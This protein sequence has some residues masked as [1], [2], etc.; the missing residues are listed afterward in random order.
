MAL[1][2]ELDLKSPPLQST[3]QKPKIDGFSAFRNRFFYGIS[4]QNTAHIL[5]VNLQ[6]VDEK[7]PG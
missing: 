6:R 3:L 1:S 5:E 4:F 7:G 2:L